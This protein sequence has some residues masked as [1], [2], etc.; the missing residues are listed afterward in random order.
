[1][2]SEDNIMSNLSISIICS[3]IRPERW[4]KVHN[5]FRRE[6]KLDFEIIFVGPKSCESKLPKEVRFIKSDL[7]ISNCFEL[8]ARNATGEYLMAI[9]DDALFQNGI[10]D[11]LYYDYAARIRNKYVVVS[12]LFTNYFKNLQIDHMRFP[13]KHPLSQIAPVC[14]LYNRE[15]WHELGGIDRRFTG[16]W[17]DIDLSFRFYEA[18]GAPFLAPDCQLSSDGSVPDK[19]SNT[20]T[21]HSERKFLYRLWVIK[22]VE[23]GVKKT[24][25]RDTRS[26][27][28]ESIKF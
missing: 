6:N 27:P 5:D 17:W 7:P 24:K 9:P 13:R 3:S 11:K 15:K 18:G 8:A 10:L 14:G 26:M 4:I 12:P 22:T 19:M 21:A 16:G 20:K 23:N 25:I 2:I 28:V 1:M